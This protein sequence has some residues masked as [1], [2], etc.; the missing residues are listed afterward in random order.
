MLTCPERLELFCAGPLGTVVDYVADYMVAAQDAEDPA[1]VL[2]CT[3]PSGSLF[4]LGDTLVTCTATDRAGNQSTCSFAVTV[5]AG[6][7]LTLVCPPDVTLEGM[8]PDGAVLEFS[9]EV[10]GGCSSAPESVSIP[11]SGSWFSL[12]TT[13][14]T[15]AASDPLGNSATCEFF[16]TVHDSV[17]PA[18]EVE[19]VVVRVNPSLPGAV[20]SFSPRVTDLCDPAPQVVCSPPSGSFF[21]V[22]RTSVTCIATDASGNQSLRVFNVRVRSSLVGSTSS[23][24]SHDTE[25]PGMP[26]GWYSGDTHEHVQYCD[27]SVHFQDEVLARMQAENLNVANILIW[28]RTLLPYTRFVCHVTGSPDPLS[29]RH[30]ILQY[31]VETS[32]LDCSR[33]GHLI[34]LN[35]RAEDARIAAGSLLA[36]DCRDMPGL[37]LEGD[38]TGMFTAPIAQ[39]FLAEPRAVCGYAHTFWPIGIYHPTGYDWNTELLA[40]GFTTDA[41]YLDPQ[42]FLAVPIVARLMGIVAP[43]TSAR[44]FLPLLGAMDVVLGNVQFLETVAQGG[45]SQFMAVNPPIDWNEMTYKLLSAGVRV[46]IGGGSDKACLM[47]G[48]NYPRTY[49]L[50]DEELSYD[51][52]T[53]GLEAGRTSVAGGAG[54]FLHLLLDGAEVGSDVPLASPNARATA[55]VE[56]RVDQAVNDCIELVVNG[57]VLDSRPAV[58]ATRGTIRVTF[59]DIPFSR[60]SWVAARL[61]SNRAHTGAVYVL[62]DG[63]P[64]ADPVR[65]EYWMLWCDVVTK[66]TLEHPE[67]QFFGQQESEVLALIARARR[68][69][70]ALRDLDGYDPAWGIERYGVSRAGC[71]GPVTIGADSPARLGEEL[72]LTCVNAPPLADGVLC[73]SRAALD[74]P[75]IAA[76]RPLQASELPGPLIATY[77]VKATRSGHAEVSIPAVPEAEHGLHAR[78]FWEHPPRCIRTHCPAGP[79]SSDALLMDVR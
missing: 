67:L 39:R 4:P 42:Q 64:I 74:G 49:V 5:H 66:T 50:V 40:S 73:I 26:P 23:D 10:L 56:L 1:P 52:W 2:V 62:V 46:S 14:V 16:V 60:S 31:G 70:Q 11:P 79:S 18:I 71:R 45:A 75:Q 28:Q 7:D 51:S 68:A 30:R 53:E 3:P 47:T 19:P 34:G 78:F 33:W 38:G 22:G 8:H 57:E 9:P 48:P 17:A 65:A 41:R 61:C 55:T 76:G 12:G 72:R 69:F 15:S 24:G 27:E 43:P 37:G 36:N 20:V 25:A 32:G 63:Q 13:R 77:A 54:T 21:P 6:G 35:I 44:A 58:R 59:A 29:G